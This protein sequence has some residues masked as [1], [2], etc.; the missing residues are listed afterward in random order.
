MHRAILQSV[1]LHIFI[2]SFSYTLF[3]A[4]NWYVS[5]EKTHNDV[6]A[7]DISPLSKDPPV[8]VDNEGGCKKYLRLKK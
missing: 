1:H 8:H 3:E 6:P 4:G 2:I 5:N 7:S